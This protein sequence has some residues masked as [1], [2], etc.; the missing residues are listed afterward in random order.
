MEDVK[1]SNKDKL[2]RLITL[3][4]L[5]RVDVTALTHTIK[6]LEDDVITIKQIVK[7]KQEDLKKKEPISTGWFY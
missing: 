2:D 7:F 1:E 6:K 5:T 3:V 4:N